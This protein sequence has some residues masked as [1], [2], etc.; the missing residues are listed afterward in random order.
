MKVAASKLKTLLKTKPG[1]G[2]NLPHYGVFTRLRPSKR[3]GVGVFA[4]RNIPKGAQIFYGDNDR[5]VW[6][7]KRKLKRLPSEL[8]RLYDDS[9]IIKDRGQTYGCPVNFNRL[10][11]PWYLNS[12]SRPNVGCD[13]RDRF[14][15]LR[16]IRS[17]EELT[18][19][20]NTYNEFR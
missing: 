12:S 8:R 14:F 5:I 9:S 11:A 13:K 18:V 10:T 16:D 2:G 3:G 19:D 20:Y 7:N 17:G 1:N 4:I 6:L 15:A